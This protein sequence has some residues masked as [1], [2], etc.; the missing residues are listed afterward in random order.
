VPLARFG[1]WQT[2]SVGGGTPQPY[3]PPPP[4]G[5]WSSAPPAGSPP[6]AITVNPVPTLPAG[7]TALPSGPVWTGGPPAGALPAAGLSSATG[8]AAKPFFGIP[9]IAL[10][11]AGGLLVFLIA[12]RL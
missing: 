2:M 6:I 9:P 5:S 7:G 8:Q 11:A 10:V 12:R 1:E 3:K 4:P